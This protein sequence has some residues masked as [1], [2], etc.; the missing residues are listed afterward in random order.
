M[1]EDD[2]RLGAGR[3]GAGSRQRIAAGNG[4]RERHGGERG[5]DQLRAAKGA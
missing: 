3:L 2:H 1:D 4:E 5:R